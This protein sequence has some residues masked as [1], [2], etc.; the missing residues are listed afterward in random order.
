MG[1]G[2]M[3]GCLALAS[4]TCCGGESGGFTAVVERDSAGVLI[5]ENETGEAGESRLWTVDD[6]PMLDIG[7]VEGAPE[8]EFQYISGAVRLSDGRI[9]VANSGSAEL[10]CF[11]EDG[12]FLWSAGRRGEGP[13][14][15]RNLGWVARLG[16]DSLVAYDRSLRRISIFDT[17]GQLIRTANLSLFGETL[18][19]TAIG[20]TEDGSVIVQAIRTISPNNV[21]EGVNHPAGWLLRYTSE[22][23]ASDTV[24]RIS[25]LEWFANSRG[26]SPVI[27]PV[28][29]SPSTTIAVSNRLVYVSRTANYEVA[30]YSPS[31]EL[32]RLI[33]LLEPPIPVTGEDIDRYRAIRLEGASGDDERR[34]L[35]HLLNEVPFPAAFPALSSIVV[36]ADGNIW[37]E[38]YRRPGASQVSFVV[39]AETGHLL[40]TVTI[41]DGL[42]VF[43]AGPEYLLGRWRDEFEVEHIRLHRINRP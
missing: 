12:R 8:Y 18:R 33:R 38:N 17:E 36:D 24:T 42:H 10:R 43:E 27:S 15:F 39:F 9:V 32:L 4:L 34:L 1:T 31:G 14:E 2:R 19:P 29:F 20:V 22:G 23:Q 3:V 21:S 40:G 11:S 13:G 30:I 41:P 7:V 35:T 26:P 37:V 16:P 28:P 25:G 6:E 5:V